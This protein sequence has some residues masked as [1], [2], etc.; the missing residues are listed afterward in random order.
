VNLARHRRLKFLLLALT[1]LSFRFLANADGAAPVLVLTDEGAENPFA[2]YLT[3]IMR[4]EGLMAFELRERASLT[5]SNQSPLSDYRAIVMGEMALS[6]TDENLLRDYV[7][8]GGV[9]IGARPDTGLEDVFGVEFAGNRPERTLQY[10]AVEESERAGA[11]I[12][13]GALQYHG[14]ATNYNLQG[15]APLAH[16][17][18]NAE[19]P[20]SYPAVTTN[21]FGQGRAIAFAFDPAKSVVLTRQGNIEWKNTEGDGIPEYRPHDMFTR[22]DGRTYYDVER[23]AIPHA[24]ELQRFLANTLIDSASAPLPRMWYLPGMNKTMMINTGDGEDNFGHQFNA[25]LDD[26]ASYGGTFSVYLRDIGVQNTTAAQEAAWRAAG[27]EVGVHMFADGAEG[28]GATAQM[29]SA[30]NRVVSALENK[31]GHTARTARSHTIDWTGWVDMARIEANRGTQ[32]DTNYYH[33]LNGNLFDSVTT[34]GYFTGSG[35]PQRFIDDNGELLGIYQAATQWTDEWYGNTGMTGPQAV[36]IMTTMF[37]TAGREGYYSAF[38]NNIHPVRYYGPD[39]TH[40][41]ANAIWQYCQERGIPMWS[42]EKLLDFTLARSESQFENLAYAPGHLEFDFVAGAA[43]FDLTLMLPIDWAG[44]QLREIL[45]DGSPIAWI[46]EEIKGIDYAMFTTTAAAAHIAASY[47]APQ[48]A[49]F[50]HDG[51]VNVVDLEQWQ[52]SFGTN[53]LADANGDGVSDGADFLAWQHQFSDEPTSLTVPEPTPLTL[54]ALA[55]LFL[56]LRPRRIAC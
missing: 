5:A 25:V 8:G 21:Q 45:V 9:L 44:D 39:V 1:A 55:S 34:N 26:A 29:T 40:E 32:L 18:A 19:T 11:G 22:T 51:Q 37:E 38:V 56:C 47:A 46:A 33:Y 49:D 10:Y 30:Y 7:A 52:Q 54:A 17:Y 50:N 53:G 6:A 36:N 31:F 14:V 43:G 15:A 42:A 41:W 13:Q 2:E 35:L 48:S 23:M 4:S 3:E 20:S 12:T 24:D 16:L 28:A 27:H